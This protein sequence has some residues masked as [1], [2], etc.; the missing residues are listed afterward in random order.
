MI[1]R[2]NMFPSTGAKQFEEVAFKNF[3]KAFHCIVLARAFF[4]LIPYTL[5]VQ[6]LASWFKKDA[7]PYRDGVIPVNR[8]MCFIPQ[9]IQVLDPKLQTMITFPLLSILYF[10]NTPLGHLNT[11]G[12]WR[13]GRFQNT[14]TENCLK[15]CGYLIVMKQTYYL[16]KPFSILSISSSVVLTDSPCMPG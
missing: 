2:L 16:I 4:L 8:K 10:G 12:Q 9:V 15:F 6:V 13:C 14:D 7:Y 1:H 11:K 5:Q 3:P